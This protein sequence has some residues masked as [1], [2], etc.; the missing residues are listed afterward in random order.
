MHHCQRLAILL[1]AFGLVDRSTSA[2]ADGPRSATNTNTQV[3]QATFKQSS[4]TSAQQQ[5][6]RFGRR[7]ARVGDQTEQTVS[8]EMRLTLSMRRENEIVGKNQTTVRTHQRRV[9]TTTAID[10]GR[11]MAVKVQYP[12]ATRQVSGMPDANSPVGSD[13]APT[14]TELPPVP[15]PVQGKSYLCHRELGENGKLVI[16]DEAGNEPR[17]EER[18]IVAQQMDM[19]GRPNPLAQFLAGRAVAVGE[20]LEL[21]KDLAKQIFNLGDKFGEVTQF[22]L[23]LQ[24]VISE[25]GVN[26]AVFS[27]SVEAASNDA[28]QMR[29]QVDGPLV[30]EVDTCRAARINLAGPIGIS[31]TRGSYSTAYQVLGTGR[32]QMSITSAFRD[33]QR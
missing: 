2:V 16:T 24:K 17:K 29:L 21:P 25:N 4:P 22:T 10:S 13:A 18:E 26:L 1:V 11:T 9:L 6:V 15:Q 12:E 32:L 7:L 23:T 28:S 19:V 27:A 20:K 33:A 8:L 31:E 5:S 14:N 30:V 3:N